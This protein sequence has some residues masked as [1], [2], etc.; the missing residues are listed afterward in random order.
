MTRHI[1]DYYMDGFQAIPFCK[2]CSAEGDALFNSCSGKPS[3]TPLN[4][5]QKDLDNQRDW[6][7]SRRDDY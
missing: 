4:T 2:L 5:T 1:L 3:V 7:D 6:L